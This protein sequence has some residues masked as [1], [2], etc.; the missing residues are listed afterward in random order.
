VPVT[1]A[2]QVLVC[3][4][5]TVAGVQLTLTEV[6]VGGV[7]VTVAHPDLLVSCV[8]VAVTVT[9]V[10]FEMEDAAVKTP[11]LLTEPPLDGLTPQ[12]TAEL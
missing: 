12:V 11:A 3:V 8:E 4:T 1:V 6:M 5:I 2:A 9:W 7:T 10:A